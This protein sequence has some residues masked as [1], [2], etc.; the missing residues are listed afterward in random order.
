MRGT[1]TFALCATATATLVALLGFAGPAHAIYRAEPRPLA[2]NPDGPV[3]ALLDGGNVVYLGGKLDGTGGI[4]AVNEST[5]ALLWM[6][7]ASNDV[8][9]LALSPDGSTLYAG[10]RFTT[11]EGV[12][13]RGVVA[14]NVANHTLVSSWKGAAA[15]TVRDLIAY[16]S[17]VYVAGKVTSVGGVAQ[18]G[19]G[20]LDATTGKR[21]GSFTFSADNDVL[22][23]ALTGTRLILSGSFTHINGVAR[24]ELASIDLSTNTLTG[25]APAKLCSSCDQYWDVQ[26][27]GTNAY[28]ATSGN[29]GGAFSLATGQPPWHTIRGTGDFQ[30]AWVPGDGHVYYGG[31]FGEGVWS[32]GSP[33]NPVPAK[34]LVAVFI[35]SGLPD[36]RWLPRHIGA[37]PGTWA[38]TS[39]QGTL[40]VG[41]DFTGEVVNGTN[42]HK[43]Y[44]AAYP[45]PNAATDTQPPTGSFHMNRATAWAK[46]TQVNLV[47]TA[48][49]DNVTPD[50]KIARTVDWGD[51]TSADWA[52]GTTLTHVYKSHGTFTPRV[53]LTDQAG[54]S[55]APIDSSAVSVKVDS[56]AP[57]VKLHLPRH[58]HSVAAW[59]TLRGTATDAGTGVQKVALQIVEK[60]GGA[61]YGYD[62]KTHHWIKAATKAKAFAKSR[63]LRVK[64]DAQHAWSAKAAHLGKGTLVYKVWATD[65]VKNRSATM[66]HK[67]SLSHR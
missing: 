34:Q 6:L 24:N 32:S 15:G 40:W 51:G 55:S 12:T 25:W 49:H 65:E 31:H 33:Q 18:R 57:V 67:A 2:W 37:Y 22:G 50:N 13:H 7:H 30:A 26:T 8:R 10:G 48:I 41:G 64:V 23:L 43:P 16:G 4:A 19:I 9:A 3:H 66:T 46:H 27:D 59:K 53:T 11:V 5:G 1:R 60:R 35:G 58:K 61:W 28:V 39:T 54:N 38:F 29:A 56:A 21:D 20:A 47:Q 63:T 62:A 36:G 17:D 42:N 52:T 14:V 45:A 44:L